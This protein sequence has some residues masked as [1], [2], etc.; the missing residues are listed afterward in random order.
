ME[1]LSKEQ[2]LIEIA[3]IYA[4]PIALM[5]YVKIQEPGEIALKF[6]GWEHIQEFLKVLCAEQYTALIKAK[7][8]GVSWTLALWAL[9]QIMFRPAWVVLE[10]SKG[11]TESK[12]LLEKSRIIYENFPS[13]LKQWTI[14]PNSTEQFGFKE[15]KSVIISYPSTESAG[16][17][18]TAGAVIHDE[19]DFHEYFRTNLSHTRATVADKKERHLVAVSTMDPTK[20]GGEFEDLWRGGIEGKNGFKSLFYGYDARPDRGEEF[21][22][23]MVLA[24]ESTPWEVKKNYPRT[25]EEALSPLSAVSCFKKEVLDNLWYNVSEAGEVREGFIHIFSRPRVG[26]KYVAGL[27]VGEGV[28]LHY[29]CLAII[30]KDGL[31]SEVAAVI[32]SNTVGTDAFAYEAD[33]LCREYFEPLLNFDNIGIGRAVADKLHELGY[34]NLYNAKR[35]DVKG[36]DGWAFNRNNR[37]ELMV[38]LIEAINNGSLKTKFKPQV[39]ELMEQQWVN[40]YSEA[41]GKT[42]GDSVDALM[43]GLEMLK[44]ISSGGKAKLFVGGRRIW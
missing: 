24:N 29:S 12:Q 18:V 38:K 15:L 2:K 37:R 23:K 17:G 40:G 14:E 10:I 31:Q 6:E 9:W 27:D 19:A 41:T 20:S 33:K 42:H 25:A 43:L 1:E 26:V 11:A 39:K 7:Q 21:Y 36:K 30:G 35:G 28:G 3:K 4:S 8:I 16:I 32:Y 22:N 5:P 13:W 34:T 44:H